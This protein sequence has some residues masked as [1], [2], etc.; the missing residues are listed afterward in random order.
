M[1]WSDKDL[2]HTLSRVRAVSDLMRSAREE[3]QTRYPASDGVAQQ[4]IPKSVWS[5]V[6]A[7]LTSYDEARRFIASLTT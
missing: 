2:D 5:K 1:K 4:P 7:A 6:R 3:L